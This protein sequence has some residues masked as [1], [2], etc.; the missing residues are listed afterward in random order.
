MVA[1]PT[2]A[3]GLNIVNEQHL[4]LAQSPEEWL[5]QLRQLCVNAALRERLA[6]QSRALVCR[7]YTWT[8]TLSRLHDIVTRGLS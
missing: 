1:S 6:E 4:L 5:N 7:D 8:A 2:A 3:T